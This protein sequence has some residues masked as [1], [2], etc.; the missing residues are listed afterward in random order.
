MRGGRDWEAQV[1]FLRSEEG[2]EYLR[3]LDKA[4]K[5]YAESL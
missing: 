5:D 1:A 4:L 2:A 3:K